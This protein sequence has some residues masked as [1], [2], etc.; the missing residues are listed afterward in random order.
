MPVNRLAQSLL[1]FTIAAI[2]AVSCQ[3]GPSPEKKGAAGADAQAPDSFKVAFETNKGRIVVQAVRTWAPRGVDRFYAL[4]NDQFYDGVKFFRVL[5]NFMAQ[6][7]IQ[8]DPAKNNLWKDRNIQDDP[9]VQSNKRGFVT[10][11]T[12]GPNT[13][14][15]QLFINK[16]DNVRLDGMGFA[17][18]ARVV[19]GMGVVD[20]LNMEYGEGAPEGRGPSQGLIEL[21][22]NRYLNRDF[23]RLDSIIRA[24]V[25]KD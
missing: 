25:L 13:R 23:P 2:A 7:G 14:T 24:R 19:E 3:R 21:E 15:T 11:A 9:V 10:F 20:S 16:R 8:G 6:F 1:A 4:V 22:G 12:G 5:P 18:F 17:P